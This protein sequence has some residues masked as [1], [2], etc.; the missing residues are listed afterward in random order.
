MAPLAVIAGGTA[1]AGVLVLLR[2]AIVW[3][4]V[5]FLGNLI[6]GLGIGTVTYVG[7]KSLVDSL[8]TDAMDYISLP[9]DIQQFAGVLRLDQILTLWTSAL[10]VKVAMI[11]MSKLVLN[12][13]GK[14]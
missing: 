14:K 13:G 11:S 5:T 4:L 7:L 2:K 6:F 8:I 1:L 3:A 10:V 9:P 12:N